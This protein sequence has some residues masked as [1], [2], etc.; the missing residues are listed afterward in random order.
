MD[1]EGIHVFG[2]MPKRLGEADL[3]NLL[4]PW[5]EQLK[6]STDTGYP[7][8][9]MNSEGE[10][11]REFVTSLQDLEA[12]ATDGVSGGF[13]LPRDPPVYY[14]QMPVSVDIYQEDGNLFPIPA[15]R[16]Y[17]H[18]DD[19]SP[20][21]DYGRKNIQSLLD[22]V[23]H[24]HEYYDLRYTY[25]FASYEA[26]PLSDSQYHLTYEE[27]ED[28]SVDT[29]YWLNIFPPSI[30]EQFGHERVTSAPAFEIRKMD[31]GAVLL[32][33]DEDP[34]EYNQDKWTAIEEC[35]ELTA[36]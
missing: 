33:V 7:C 29:L 21:S 16:L 2:V 12:L 31:S 4:Q 19:L 28:G 32:V 15:Y 22:L 27:I 8:S 3:Y 5:F 23:T 13:N 34:V 17:V 26:P 25:G 36:V 10:T 30:V 35:L 9:V 24:M 20:S 11:T 18:W 6:P 14:D 1:R